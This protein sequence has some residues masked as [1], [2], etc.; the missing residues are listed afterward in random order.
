MEGKWAAL[1]AKRTAK[2]NKSFQDGF[3]V[4]KANKLVLL[5][6]GENPL[7]EKFRGQRDVVMQGSDLEFDRYIVQVDSRVGG[8]DATGGSSSTKQDLAAEKEDLSQTKTKALYFPLKKKLKPSIERR[9]TN[10][11]LDRL[12]MPNG[13]SQ[14][15]SSQDA[16]ASQ[17]FVCDENGKNASL[18]LRLNIVPDVTPPV[19][20]YFQAAGQLQRNVAIP[21]KFKDCS[22]YKEVM[23]SAL[24]E[25]IS[26]M[27]SDFA[28]RFNSAKEKIQAAIMPSC[29]HGEC[30]LRRNDEDGN[31]KGRWFYTCSRNPPC[32]K[33]W[34][35]TASG[36]SAQLSAD[37]LERLYAS[38][39]IN[40][41][42]HCHLVRRSSRPGYINIHLGRTVPLNYA[43]GDLMVI[44]S[45]SNFPEKNS[46][47]FTVVATSESFGSSR[48]AAVE[49]RL[50]G[51]PVPI[52]EGKKIYVLQGPSLQSE[53][54]MLDCI[55]SNPPVRRC[56]LF[57]WDR[58]R[59][60]LDRL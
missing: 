13:F 22:E 6:E 27:I 52:R 24:I 10:E 33:S 35:D 34:A 1:Y 25:E 28:R 41:Y 51:Q 21:D 53:L 23:S 2:K 17:V 43:K 37:E 36:K 59:M 4:V 14:E 8:T 5:D 42:A 58:I 60:C 44:S 32:M 40:L 29:S 48:N 54:T 56:Y 26:L 16:Q 12:R 38:Y 55:R 9:T 15:R 20:F 47:E 31:F 39:D 50:H 19:Q 49:L 30:E 57:L 46:E 11:I 7:D 3:L 45:S 18:C